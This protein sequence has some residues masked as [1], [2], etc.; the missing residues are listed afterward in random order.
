MAL[1][2]LSVPKNEFISALTSQ[3]STVL[4]NLRTCLFEEAR[5]K[6]L[7]HPTDV[8]VTRRCSPIRPITFIHAEDIWKLAISLSKSQRIPRTLVK[9]GKRSGS[10]LDSWRSSAGCQ[11]LVEKSSALAESLSQQVPTSQ[12][13]PSPATINSPPDSPKTA[14]QEIETAARLPLPHPNDVASGL[15]MDINVIKQ[16]IA[17]IRL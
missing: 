16:D 13:S 7:T 4:F 6:D 1:T 2:N 9:N 12:L 14:S 3:P 5:E 10:K 17:D 11:S 8:L 15:M